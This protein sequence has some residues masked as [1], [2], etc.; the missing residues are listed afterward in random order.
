MERTHLT[1]LGRAF[2]GRGKRFAADLE[3]DLVPRLLA[4]VAARFENYSDFGGTLTG[5]IAARLKPAEQLVIRGAFSTGFRAPG[6][7]QSHY[8]HVSTGF[9]AEL[10]ELG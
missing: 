9:R 3:G 7:N 5:K 2:N 8:A 6:L 10:D 4:N 1:E